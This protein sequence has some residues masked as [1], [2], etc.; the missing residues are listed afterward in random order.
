MLAFYRGHGRA[1]PWR[2]TRA[3]YGI[4]IAEVMLQQ[5]RVETVV[6]RFPVFLRRFPDIFALAAAKEASVCQAW[7]GLGYYGRA[8]NLH[9]A[10]AMIVRQLDGRL[11]SDA[12]AWRRL[13]G[14]GEYTAAAIASI[15]FGERAAAV[16]G[17]VVRVLAR[18]FALPGRASDPG[19]L[20]AVR[21]K[22]QGL[23]ACE[24]PGDI[25]QAL[26]DVGATLC[27]PAT[28]ACAACPLRSLCRA[29]RE[30]NA[31]AYPGKKA[32]APRRIL[33]IAFAFVEI[34]SAL[35]LERRPLDGLW[36][37]LW[38]LPSASGPSAKRN[39]G[40]RLGHAPGPLLARVGHDLSHRRVLASV[41]R[42]QATRGSRQKWWRDPLA[43]PLSAL[44][45]KA[46]VAARG[47]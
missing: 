21:A 18:V 42:A 29:R 4:W 28:P 33:R 39:L 5:T 16:D 19:L 23:V 15:A 43:A 9:R 2:E 47:G 8:R 38:E 17:N 40:R 34:G 14:V 31:A 22:A 25:N 41:Y 45:R 6:P 30:G 3:P 44:A 32:R 1:L 36:A 11:P 46:I 37:G 35:L 26:M 27:R 7:A 10:A 20:R 24:H 12:S 13:P